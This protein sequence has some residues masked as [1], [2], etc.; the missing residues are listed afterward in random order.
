MSPERAI[1]RT[2]PLDRPSPNPPYSDG[3]GPVVRRISAT[4][5]IGV[6]P[7]VRRLT[8]TSEH[9]RSLARCMRANPAGVS[10]EPVRD[11]RR[12]AVS[13]HPNVTPQRVVHDSHFPSPVTDVACVCRSRRPRSSAESAELVS[14]SVG[15]AIVRVAR[16]APPAPC[17]RTKMRYRPRDRLNRQNPESRANRPRT[18]RGPGIRPPCLHE[19]LG[20]FR[21]GGP[22]GVK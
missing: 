1:S 5:S 19:H 3:S 16:R 6:T 18:R 4:G 11:G 17:G 21:G 8:S 7:T 22:D 10:V 15:N 2:R 13:A 12:A 20:V 9:A 14:E